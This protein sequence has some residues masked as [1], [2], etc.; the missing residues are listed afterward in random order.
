MAFEV[1]GV[2]Q[3]ESGSEKK[4]DF[5]KL[6]EY[7]VS[8]AQL[9]NR[10]TLVGV[11]SMIVD[12]GTQEQPDA[13]VTF[14][15]DEEDEKKAIAEKPQT[16]FKDGFDPETK[17]P[18]RLKCWPQKPIQSVA[19][20]VDFPDIIV[21]KGQFFGE[22]KPLPLRLWLGGQ[23]YI[24]DVGM[25]IG[26][27]TPLKVNKKLGD[28]SLDQKH[29][30]YKMAVASKLIKP[31][32]VFKPQQIDQLL[33]K[34]YQFEAQVFFKENKGK[35]YYTEY[36][37]F[38]SGL[39]R[40]Q[41]EPELFVQP[42]MIQFNKEN[43]PSAIKDLRN[44]V[45]STLKRAVNYQG[46]AIQK[47]I[48]AVRGTKENSSQEPVKEEKKESQAP[49]EPKEDKTIQQASTQLEQSDIDDSDDLPF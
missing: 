34:A 45:V 9:E 24:P 26:R 21:D 28:W 7:V 27:P 42:M 41:V 15:G 30:F 18:V 37:K 32:E 44:H 49:V 6:N 11:V 2:D 40:G 19:V 12:I 17:K 23:F 39:G 1:Y 4:V 29:L 14:V 46:S 10:E 8:T 16:Y 35:K 48:E 47:Q 3:K 33:G 13:E 36:I 5:E 31:G 22:S 20:A 25:V 38:V 43:D